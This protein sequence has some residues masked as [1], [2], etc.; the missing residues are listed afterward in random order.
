MKYGVVGEANIAAKNVK[1]YAWCFVGHNRILF[2]EGAEVARR[3]RGTKKQVTRIARRPGATASQHLR[4][5]THLLEDDHSC[6]TQV[7]H[8][9]AT[10]K[11]E[12]QDLWDV[13][14]WKA[15]T[16]VL[17]EVSRARRTRAA[18]H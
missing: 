7:E 5:A 18:G 4:N 2:A 6:Q 11:R 10:G 14:T 8:C 15:T 13:M 3:T 12:A 9:G 16:G 17:T 1:E